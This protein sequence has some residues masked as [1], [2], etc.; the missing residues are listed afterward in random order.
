MPFDG[1]QMDEI[2]QLLITG[3]ENVKK[4]WCQGAYYHSGAVCALGAL[5]WRRGSYRNRSQVAAA[6]LL[7][8][9]VAMPLDNWNDLPTT[10]QKDV[11]EL[12]ERAIAT[13]LNIA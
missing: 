8:N 10:T 3:W 9:M 7:C 13:R 4:G 6:T 12:F 11:E 5:G 1:T 2:T